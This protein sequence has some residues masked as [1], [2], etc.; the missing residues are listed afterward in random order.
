MIL[1]KAVISYDTKSTTKEKN[2]LDFTEN[3]NLCALK[4]TTKKVE[5]TTHRKEKVFTIYRCDEGLVPEYL[6]KSSYNS[7]SFDVK[8]QHHLKIGKEKNKNRQR[9]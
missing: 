1:N 7:T 2:K 3:V 5:K 8:R 9:I 4:N 6:K